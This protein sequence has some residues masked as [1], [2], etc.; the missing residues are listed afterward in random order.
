MSVLSD[1]A[2][3]YLRLRNSLG[4]ELAEHHRQLPRFV[5]FLDAAGL[6]TVTVAAAL[7]WAQGPDV[8]PASSMAPRRMT[9]AAS[10]A[11]SPASTT[12]LKSHHQG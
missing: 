7:A 12:A 5:A 2:H 10:R 3:D 9:P 6:P 4:H 11:T 1:A 8:D